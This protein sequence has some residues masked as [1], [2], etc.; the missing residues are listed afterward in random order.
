MRSL[1]PSLSPTTHHRCFI[2][3]FSLTVDCCAPWTHTLP[4]QDP[5]SCPTQGLP[6]SETK[7]AAPAGDSQG[8]QGQSQPQGSAPSRWAPCF[9]PDVRQ[10]VESPPWPPL[11]TDAPLAA[12]CLQYTRSP[13]APEPRSRLYAN[14][15]PSSGFL[16]DPLGPALP[17]VMTDPLKHVG[18]GHSSPTALYSSHLR[19]GQGSASPAPSPAASLPSSA[20]SL[21]CSHCL[22]PRVAGSVLP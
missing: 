9:P 10:C 11:L 12:P 19:P 14:P 21:P 8:L 20:P 22:G 2:R 6:S 15:L 4:S 17:M 7:P 3:C 13:A 1:C 16:P 5:S 18:S